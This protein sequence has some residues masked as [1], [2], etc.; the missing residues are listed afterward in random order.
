MEIKTKNRWESTVDTSITGTITDIQHFSIHDGPGIRSSVF[1]KGCALRCLWCHNPENILV[2]ERELSFIPA[3]CILCGYCFR[4]CPNGC[5]SLIDGQHRVDRS[6]CQRCG[7]CAAECYTKAITLVGRTVT[8][9]EVVDEVARD[10]IFYATSGGGIT[11]SGGEPLMQREFTREILRLCKLRGIHTTLET[12]GVYPYEWLDG[13]RENVDLF[14]LDYK[15]T[16][17]EQH[18]ECTG[19]DGHEVLENLHRLQEDGYRVLLRCP[20]IP[21]KNDTKEHFKAIAELTLTYPHLLGAE[22]LPYHRLGTSK[23]DRFGLD[24][25][26]PHQEY[27]TPDKSTVRAWIQI[28]RDYGG[29]IINE[30]V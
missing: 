14:F 3:R 22:L 4:V 6:K 28:V 12:C 30:D 20:I 8:A 1:F 15:A 21:G 9:Q 25:Q 29:R 26:L 17:P 7:R 27:S 11:L 23:I 18:K 13:I 24:S 16:G 5:H 10:D 19:V 2:R